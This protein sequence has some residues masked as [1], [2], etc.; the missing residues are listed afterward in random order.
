MGTSR[1]NKLFYILLIAF[2][3]DGCRNEPSKEEIAA[4]KREDTLV[5]YIR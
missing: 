5:K 3:V 4:A 1:V 2:M